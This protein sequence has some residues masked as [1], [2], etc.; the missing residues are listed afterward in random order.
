MS[1][2]NV[3]ELLPKEGEVFISNKYVQSTS[4]K[5]LPV[6]NPA[7]E[8]Q[9]YK[10][11]ICNDSDVK[12]AVESARSAQSVW[13]RIHPR[14]R[15]KYLY[16]IAELIL[17]HKNELAL[18]ETMNVGKPISVML[19]REIPRTAELITYYAGWCDKITGSTNIISTNTT[20]FVT[21]EPVGVA[22]GIVPWNFP[23]II[24]FYKIAPA[25]VCG[26]SII[27]KPSEHSPLTALY[28]GKIFQE[29]GL[30]EGVVNIVTGDGT[31]GELLVK[32]PINKIAFT[33]SIETG[34][35]ILRS[36]SNDLKRVHLELGGKSPHVIF[37]DA[38]IDASIESAVNGIF[39]NSGQVCIAGSR[40][41]VHKSIHDQ[42]LEKLKRK[43]DSIVTGD[44]LS[45]TTTMGPICNKM[46]F[47]K[48]TRYMS[49][50]IQENAVTI[51]GG[52]RLD[53]KGY[54]VKPTIFDRVNQ[55]S[56]IAKEEIFGPVLS[57]I[58]F[59]TMENLVSMTNSTI[60]G[61]AAGC[62]TKDINKAMYFAKTV[63]A[64]IVWIN[65]FYCMDPVS[66]FGGFKQSGF[67]RDLG[68][69][70]L[71]NYLESKSIIIMH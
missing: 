41:F 13:E 26:N 31:T 11:P 65:S 42:Y 67:G 40:L 33:G 18:L 35:K 36:C 47:E 28:M 4:D 68:K 2:F 34:K 62:W 1:K 8:E 39:Y 19:N 55:G 45:E 53:Q 69:E 44:P 5:W 57:C 51:T 56:T 22:A 23:L 16:K 63:K 50:A 54:F 60:Y 52:S 38:P 24:A 25:I 20:L 17:K 58:E 21:E 15:G 32:S 61:L 70:S 30:P 12:M 29:A 3:Q 37:E 10:I 71:N 27:L 9:I 43:V 48:I 7:T 46:Q 64:G 59:D 6:I 66:P 14:E 49:T